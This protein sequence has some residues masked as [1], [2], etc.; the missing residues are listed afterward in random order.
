MKERESEERERERERERLKSK[1]KDGV[2]KEGGRGWE[3]KFLKSLR[4]ERAPEIERLSVV[5][6][7]RVRRGSVIEK[8]S[9]V[10]RALEVKLL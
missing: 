1:R 2:K 8:S 4:L 9:E 3:T 5:T 10:L 7:Q 6:T